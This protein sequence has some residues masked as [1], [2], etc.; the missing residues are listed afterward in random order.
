MAF[1]RKDKSGKAKLEVRKGF[2][3]GIRWGEVPPMHKHFSIPLMGPTLKDGLGIQPAVFGNK[4]EVV[5]N[6]DPNAHPFLENRDMEYIM[7]FR[8]W[9]KGQPASN[10]TDLLDN[11][12]RTIEFRS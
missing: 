7:N 5:L 2:P 11:L 3:C 6:R 9:R 4:R 12:V 1:V 10:W 8:L